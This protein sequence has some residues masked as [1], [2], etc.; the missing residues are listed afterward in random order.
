MKTQKKRYIWIFIRV[1]W[2]P[3]PRRE[4]V[5][6]Y[7]LPLSISITSLLLLILLL[8]PFYI[9]NYLNNNSICKNVTHPHHPESPIFQFHYLYLLP[10]NNYMP[11]LFAH[12][13]LTIH[14]AIYLY[15]ILYIVYLMKN[16]RG[17]FFAHFYISCLAFCT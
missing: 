12:D 2:I 13:T 11:L 10:H 4:G 6:I 17:T 7:I 5:L 8:F 1:L 15:R 9:L 14:P 3:S 16:I